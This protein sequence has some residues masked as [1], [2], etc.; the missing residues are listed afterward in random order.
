M[1][2]SAL[3]NSQFALKY[4]HAPSL[5]IRLS[6]YP[7]LFNLQAKLLKAAEKTMRL[8]LIKVIRWRRQWQ[9]ARSKVNIWPHS[10]ETFEQL[11]SPIE[12]Y[13]QEIRSVCGD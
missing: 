8:K 9:R 13:K 3:A 1:I 12:M 7:Q 6:Y 5:P 2:D 10:A 4:I 11:L